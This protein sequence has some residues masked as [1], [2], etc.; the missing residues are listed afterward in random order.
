MCPNWAAVPVPS[1][2]PDTPLPACVLTI[3][4]RIKSA[5]EVAVCP[6]TVTDILPLVTPAGTVTVNCV[7]VAAETVAVVPLNFTLLVEAFA[8]KLVPV[9]INCSPAA[10]A[11]GEKPAI[12]G[13][14][15]GGGGFGEPPLSHPVFSIIKKDKK[16]EGHLNS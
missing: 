1:A 10:A 2:K 4:R 16:K 3:P 15:G 5:D 6:F 7:F 9:I 13:D 14:G 12:V 8:L 11:D